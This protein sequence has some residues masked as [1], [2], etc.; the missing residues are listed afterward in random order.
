MIS[1]V[2]HLVPVLGA[3]KSKVP[4]YILAGALALWALVLG[5]V[6]AVR[7]PD[8]PTSATGQRGVMAI[9][10]VLVL[11]TAI[12]AVATSSGD[13]N[14]VS[15]VIG[16]TPAGGNVG[17][18]GTAA[19][20]STAS[21]PTTGGTISESAEPSGALAFTKPSLHATAGRV[22]INFANMAPEMHNM[23]IASGT[24]VLAATPTF[25]GGSK[26]LSLTLKPGTYVFYCS[27]PGHRQAGMQGTLTVS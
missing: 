12:A 2:L 6:I 7:R 18:G 20:G 10:A 14:T 5:L 27:V 13:H 4:F 22:T 24:T 11:G 21:T 19:P 15:A 3:T 8:F 16:G 17:T 23:T 26:T 1:A 9:T 25:T